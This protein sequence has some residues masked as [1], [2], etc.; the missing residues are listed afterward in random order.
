MQMPAT[1]AGYRALGARPLLSPG[2]ANG[3]EIGSAPRGCTSHSM[4]RMPVPWVFVL[5][6]LLLAQG[7]PGVLGYY[8]AVNPLRLNDAIPCI[9][10]LALGVLW[11]D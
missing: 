6:S 9:C 5:P 7:G 10:R 3:V 11:G 4:G 1:G 8:G 2:C